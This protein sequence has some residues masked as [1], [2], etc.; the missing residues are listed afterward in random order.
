MS[1]LRGILLGTATNYLKVVSRAVCGLIAFRLL[2]GTL[3]DAD[4][5]FWVLLWSTFGF[6]VLVDFGFGYAVGKVVARAAGDPT[7]EARRAVRAV[8]ASVFW[9][10]AALTLVVA[11]VCVLGGDRLLAY[12]FTQ[13]GIVDPAQRATLSVVALVFVVGMLAS[14]PFGLFREVLRARHRLHFANLVDTLGSIVQTALVAW[15]CHAG[16]TLHGFMVAGIATTLVPILVI[17]GLAMRDADLRPDPRRFSPR[18][19][20]SIGAFSLYAY[21]TT[22]CSQV[23]SRCDALL[24]A[25][26]HSLPAVAWYA[27]G[28]KLAET[29]SLLAQ[30]MQGMLAATSAHLD[31]A[32]RD[33]AARGEALRRLLLV[34]Q[35]WAVLLGASLIVPLL[36]DIDGALRVLNGDAS[37]IQASATVAW[38]LLTAT[39]CAV[40]GSSCGKELLMMTGHHRAVFVFSLI[41]A[42]AKLTLATWL[43]VRWHSIVGAALGSLL[44]ALV[45][46]LIAV[47]WYTR[48][49]FALRWRDLFAAAGRGLAGSVGAIAAGLAW[50]AWRPLTHP[51][52][53]FLGGC[54]VV[55]VAMLPGW[56]W[57]GMVESERAHVRGW[58]QRLARRSR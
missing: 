22:L 9:V 16:W 43:L 10:N 36:I 25:H 15:G 5:G 35:R 42:I 33:Q 8:V 26:L 52:A 44:P 30:Q 18:D 32:A 50:A 21:L 53:D 47:P 55:A 7:P 46:H 34:S 56:W 1:L 51:T 28:Q 54:A 12:L 27:S 3:G 38:L 58:G 29:Y 45:I 48:R 13:S 19:L 17:A 11:L 57:L 14:Y 2:R 39:A 24:I 37:L 31:A 6:M 49:V 4:F 40:A 20:A 23:T 41:E